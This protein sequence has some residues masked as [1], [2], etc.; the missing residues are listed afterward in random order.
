MYKGQLG[1][2]EELNQFWPMILFT[3]L[4]FKTD[5]FFWVTLD[6]IVVNVYYGKPKYCHWCFMAD[7]IHLY[8]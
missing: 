2:F 3:S 8:L 1:V 4:F 5:Q 7:L 6:V